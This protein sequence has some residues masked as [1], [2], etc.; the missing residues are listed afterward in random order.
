MQ[1]KNKNI[2]SA[3][4]FRINLVLV[5]LLIGSLFTHLVVANHAANQRYAMQEFQQHYESLRADQQRLSATVAELK[6]TER[7]IAESERLKLVA[8]ADIRYVSPKGP[9]ALNQ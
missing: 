4:I 9:V 8:T 6:S 5:L 1:Q 7:L 2:K 3:V